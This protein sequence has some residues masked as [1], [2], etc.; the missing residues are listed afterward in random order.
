VRGD[1]D[2]QRVAIARRVAA[3]RA[4]RDEQNRCRAG[5]ADQAECAFAERGRVDQQIASGAVEDDVLALVLERLVQLEDPRAKLVN[6]YLVT[7]SA[8]RSELRLML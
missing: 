6:V 2:P 5:A 8:A 3:A 1:L 4:I 7:P